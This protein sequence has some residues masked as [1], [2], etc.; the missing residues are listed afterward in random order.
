MGIGIILY[1]MICGY[2][3]FEDNDNEI[4]F[5]KIS[6]CNI[7]YPSIISK[8]A[9]NLMKRIIVPDPEKRIKIEEIKLHPYYLQGE[10]IFKHKHP[11]FFTSKNNIPADIG[12]DSPLIKEELLI[13]QDISNNKNEAKKNNDEIINNNNISE[14]K[15]N[16]K[17][18]LN[19]EFEKNEINTNIKTEQNIEKRNE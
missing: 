3:P 12:V 6:K 9:K 17:I 19:K 16:E 8:K 18:E 2:L 1:A 7:E 13:R 11:E 14:R 15:E 5:Q 4:L 10:A